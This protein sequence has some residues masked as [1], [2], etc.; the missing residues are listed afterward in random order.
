MDYADA[1]GAIYTEWEVGRTVGRLT[2]AVDE[3]NQRIATE[4]RD[5][6]S[7]YGSI[8]LNGGS[9]LMIPALFK[10]FNRGSDDSPSPIYTLHQ[11][12]KTSWIRS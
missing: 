6:Q 5:F 8:M 10:E 3:L 9:F 11:R 4:Y 2:G 12:M 7:A 1:S